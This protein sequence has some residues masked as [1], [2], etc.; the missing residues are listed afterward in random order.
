MS[1][2]AEGVKLGRAPLARPRVPCSF[3]QAFRQ[4]LADHGHGFRPHRAG[5][6]QSLRTPVLCRLKN[7][8]ASHE[9]CR[10][11]RVARNQLL[12]A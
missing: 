12:P 11:P 9:I 4:E 7:S 1:K 3:G 10:G 6:G 8:I 2:F 5:I